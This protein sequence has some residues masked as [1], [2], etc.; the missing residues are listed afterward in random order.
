MR[1]NLRW[2]WVTLHSQHDGRPLCPELEEIHVLVN[3]SFNVRDVW[4]G[5]LSASVSSSYPYF[6]LSAHLRFL[7]SLRAGL[8]L[9]R[10]RLERSAGRPRVVSFMY[11]RPCSLCQVLPS[12]VI[13]II[14]ISD[15]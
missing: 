6:Y 13:Q 11:R 8:L 12:H 15:L 3:R 9:R 1:G 14:I 5:L 7:G 10:L 4:R 2:C